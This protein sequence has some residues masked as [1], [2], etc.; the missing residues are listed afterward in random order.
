MSLLVLGINHNTATVDVREKVAFVPEVMHDALQQA[1]AKAGLAE[2][3]ILSTC[4]RTELFGVPEA[5]APPDP[6]IRAEQ[7]RKLLQ[8][9]AEF[10]GLP[11]SQLEPAVYCQRDETAVRHMMRVASGLD[12]MVL[13]EPQ[14]LGQIKSA[15]AVAQEAATVGSTLHRVFEDVFAVAKQVR[16]ETAIGENPVSVA[17][18]AVTLAQQIFTDIHEASALMIG[19]GR[20]IE[21]VVQH[22]QEAGVANIVVANRTLTNAQELKRKYGV[23]EVLLSDIPDELVR[24]DIV[25]SS[26][27]SQ[28]PILGKGAVET[29][30]RARR[31]KPIFMV[32]L[33]VPRDIEPEVGELEDVFLYSVDDLR[34]VI[35][36]NLKNRQEAAREA[37]AIIDLGVDTWVRKERGLEVVSTL[38]SFREKAEHIRDAE[39]DKAL[40]ALEKGAPAQAVVRELARLLTNKLIHAPS[41]QMKKAG[42]DGQSNLIDL[43][44]QLFELEASNEVTP[45]TNVQALPRQN[46]SSKQS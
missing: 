37:E 29:A 8:W 40:K 26:T 27:A 5:A 28:L 32:D 44:V 22:L 11:L 36:V 46:P 43:A 23:R 24:A 31:H 33:A 45:D 14:I 21:L 17:F 4:N 39:L 9:L 18:A 19:A 25:V 41:V 34:Q 16:T 38:R 30:L 2:V 13:G 20:T 15:Y 1:C 12:S 10:H 42:A 35:D 6:A 7:E 3:A